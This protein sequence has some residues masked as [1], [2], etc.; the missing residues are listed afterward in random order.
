MRARFI[1][2]LT[3]LLAVASCGTEDNTSTSA[4]AL[5][6]EQC[7]YF[8]VS[9]KVQ[10]CHASGS[11]NHPYTILKVSEHVCA[12]AHAGHTSDYLAVDDPTCGGGGCLPVGAP[13][14]ATLP[15]CDGSSCTAGTCI[16]V[17]SPF[18]CTSVSSIVTDTPGGAYNWIGAWFGVTSGNAGERFGYLLSYDEPSGAVGQGYAEETSSPAPGIL[19]LGP[20]NGGGIPEQIL[21]V[22]TDSG[23]L[24]VFMPSLST[25]DCVRTRLYVAADGSTYHSRA[26]H[27]Y[28]YSP[29]RENLFNETCFDHGV[30]GPNLTPEEAL[31]PQHLAR[32]AG[33]LP[34]PPP[35]SPVVLTVARA[36]NGTG[37][38][39]STPFGIHCGPD[40]S[41][42]YAPGTVVTLTAS[43]VAKSQFVGWSG[44]GC[45]GTGTCTVTLTAAT[46]VT[47]TFATSCAQSWDLASDFRIS[48]DQENPSRD[49]FGNLAV[50]HYLDSAS[51][52]RDP[53]TYTPLSSFTTQFF[54][55]NGLEGWLDPTAPSD[56]L[57]V[58]S[59]ATGSFQF[60][61]DQVDWPD[62]AIELHPSYDRLVI[63]GWRSPITGPI[64]VAGG[65]TD[66]NASCGN[67]I[68]WFVTHDGTDLAGGV[69]DNGGAQ[70]FA[71]G[72]LDLAVTAGDFVYIVLDPRDGD[73]ACDS[74]RVDL[75]I[76]ACN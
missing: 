58:I 72:A 1:L 65:V 50:W 52:A 43:A 36:G 35:P 75:T 64:S 69:I 39:S 34:P 67:G 55:I 14:D 8:D 6:S 74:T 33:P 3:T 11:V 16:E 27:D 49:R 19:A 41:E 15:C 26:D 46:A 22:T 21:T 17:R 38:V 25:N 23:S 73:Y 24:A 71:G 31:V 57:H 29:D 4:Q 63:V 37:R 2:Q 32:A 47:A 30:V 12:S 13:C 45:S 76:S 61:Y 66:A 10:I 51:L 28:T 70:S 48:P 40:C 62:G 20:S 42:S 53:A 56:T 54:A 44:G 5:T 9:G 59:N 18:S 7:D 60:P 68:A